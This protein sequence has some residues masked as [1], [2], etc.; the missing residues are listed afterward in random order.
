MLTGYANTQTVIRAIN[1]G[2][3]FRFFTKP[4]NDDELLAAV[5]QAVESVKERELESSLLQAPN[6]SGKESEELESRY[7]GI[8]KIRKDDKGYVIL[9]DDSASE[10]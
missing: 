7:P 10:P 6:E 9:D 3:I 1:D 2:E 5:R 4:W 8:T